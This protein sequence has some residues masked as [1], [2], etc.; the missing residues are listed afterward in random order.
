VCGPPGRFWLSADYLLWWIKDGHVPPLVTTSP[1]S[2]GGILTNAGTVTLFGPDSSI[3]G[4]VNSGGQFTAGCWFNEERTLGLEAG[5][6]FL[7]S[8]GRNFA[9][10]GTGDPG[11]PTLA[12]PF[13]NANTGMEDAEIVAA[14]GIAA[15]QVT[16]NTSSRLQGAQANA[17][18]NLCCGCGYRI[19]LLTGFRYLGLNE[20]VGVTEDITV[21]PTGPLPGGTQFHVNDGFATSNRFYGGQVGARGEVDFGRLFANFTGLVALGSSQEI[22]DITGSTRITTAAGAVTTA[23]GGLLALPTNIGHY[24]HTR[25]GVVPTGSLNLGY[26]V[27]DHLRASVGYTFLYWSNVARPGDQIDRVVNPVAL[28]TSMGAGGASGPARPSFL[29]RDTDFWAQGV[30]FGL[31]FRY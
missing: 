9:A 31:E 17:L 19:D 12:R 4:P 6:F 2:S 16:V 30:S 13:F 15:G 7:G 22:V 29:L 14:P 1:A 23:N 26:R 28:P 18:C 21:L 5:Y 24:G 25:F 3:N 10:S 27:T 8:R 11:T 20:G